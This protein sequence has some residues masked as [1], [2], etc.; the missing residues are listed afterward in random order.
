MVRYLRNLARS[1]WVHQFRDIRVSDQ[2]FCDTTYALCRLGVIIAEG[3]WSSGGIMTQ[4]AISAGVLCLLLFGVCAPGQLTVYPTMDGT[5]LRESLVGS[6]D[7][8]RAVSHDVR[9]TTQGGDFLDC[10]RFERRPNA[11]QTG[12]FE[13]TP[14]EHG[15][16]VYG[17]DRGGVV[18]STGDVS[19]YA[20][21]SS[22]C[23]S[24]M[25]ICT[26]G[27]SDHDRFDKFFPENEAPNTYHD[28]AEVRVGFESCV[29]QRIVLELAFGSKE[30]EEYS[31]PDQFPDSAVILL[32]GENIATPGGEILRVTPRPDSMPIEGTPLDGVRVVDGS[33]LLRFVVPVEAGVHTLE[34]IIF[35][36]NDQ[37]LDSTLYLQRIRTLADFGGD[38]S[39]SVGDILDMLGAWS[40]GEDRADIDESGSI[41]VGDILDFLGEWSLTCAN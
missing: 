10:T 4:R 37:Q 35:D 25:L 33:P 27:R 32:D 16:R 38:G 36:A 7:R 14:D 13:S 29:D 34:L 40:N 5:V 18:L 26:N 21:G 20:S 1:A 31:N 23:E 24:T 6:T 28:I 41:D 3:T 39:I 22:D 17:L 15:H 30:F 12:T 2:V 19:E 8:I 11:R 9:A